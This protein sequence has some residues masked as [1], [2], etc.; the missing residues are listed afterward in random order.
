MKYFPGNIA[1]RV[2]LI[3]AMLLAVALPAQAVMPEQLGLGLVDVAELDGKH[4]AGGIP[5][6]GL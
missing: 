2:F 4:D 1:F 5:Q 3:F 6:Q